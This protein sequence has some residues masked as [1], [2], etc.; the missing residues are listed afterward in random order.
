MADDLDRLNEA[1][2]RIDNALRTLGEQSIPIGGG[3][4]PQMTRSMRRFGALT[5]LVSFPL[6]VFSVFAGLA[7]LQ[8]KPTAV[9]TTRKFLLA[10]IAVALF[11]A[12]ILPRML[13]LESIPS[14]ALFPILV[15]TAWLLY[16]ARSRRVKVLFGQ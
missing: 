6:I 15:A 4:I 16:L 13:G 10:N 14:V 9:S 3:G 12:F 7:L 2:S 11:S 8:K 1:E 5:W